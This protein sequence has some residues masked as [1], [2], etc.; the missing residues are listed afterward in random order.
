MDVRPRRVGA[1]AMFKRP[2]A[3][4][5]WLERAAIVVAI[6]L[7]TYGLILLDTHVSTTVRSACILHQ[8]Y[9]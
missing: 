2:R 3:I 9:S 8:T 7:L 5:V 4:A 1:T 6:V